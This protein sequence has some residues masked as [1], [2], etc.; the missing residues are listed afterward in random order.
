MNWKRK[1]KKQDAVWPTLGYNLSVCVTVYLSSMLSLPSLVIMT[2]H[3]GH[4]FSWCYGV[5]E[6][7]AVLQLV[8]QHNHYWDAEDALSKDVSDNGYKRLDIQEDNISKGKTS[9]LQKGH[10]NLHA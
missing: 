10:L 8:V 3:E 7:L 4:H 9:S 6:L 5:C 1:K 2:P